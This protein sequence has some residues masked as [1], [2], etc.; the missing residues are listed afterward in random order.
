MIL[1]I[2]APL[3][4]KPNRL[5]YVSSPVSNS[6]DTCHAYAVPH[7][8]IRNLTYHVEG[9]VLQ[10]CAK[11]THPI[12]ALFVGEPLFKLVDESEGR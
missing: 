2:S 9:I 10:P 12:R 5:E 7:R 8:L 6:L 4:T 11:I 1:S 3:S